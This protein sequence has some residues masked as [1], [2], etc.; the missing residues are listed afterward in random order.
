MAG[1]DINYLAVSGVLDV[2]ARRNAPPTPPANLLA[3]F[4]SGGLLAAFGVLL[5][6]LRRTSTGKGAI[7]DAAMT[8]GS[9]YLA[10]FI[11]RMKQAGLWNAPTG[12][13]LLDSG[14]PFYGP[15]LPSPLTR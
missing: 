9:A 15:P 10:S 3:D 7:I 11:F 13:N 4:A 5:A 12:E 14:A 6:L 1:H 2:L 8:D